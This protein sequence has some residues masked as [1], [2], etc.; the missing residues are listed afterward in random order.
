MKKR[1][2]LMFSAAVLAMTGCDMFEKE[3]GPKSEPALFAVRSPKEGF[4]G[5]IEKIDP[6][7]GAVL[8]AISINADPAFEDG[9]A[10]DGRFLYYINGRTD[11]VGLNK[12]IQIDAK[13]GLAVDTFATEFP[14]RMDALAID[15]KDLYVLD[16]LQKKIYKV[17]TKT[18]TITDTIVPA[19]DGVAIG[20]MGFGGKRG[21]IFISSF[22]FFEPDTYKVYEINATTGAVVNSFAVSIPVAGVTYSETTKK[23]YITTIEGLALENITYILDPNT[24]AVVGQFAGGGSALASDESSR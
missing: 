22:T 6:K 17:N 12:V 20:G 24:G 16:F 1:N 14:P 15:K 5:A 23:L 7:T 2:F 21:T 8:K 11:L 13:S 18:K 10:Y 19:F 3:V 9:L 4:S